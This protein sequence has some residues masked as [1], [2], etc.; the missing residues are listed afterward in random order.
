M[1]DSTDQYWSPSISSI[2]D[3]KGKKKSSAASKPSTDLVVPPVYWPYKYALEPV[4]EM[5]DDK[6][7]KMKEQ[8]RSLKHLSQ[9]YTSVQG[10]D[11]NIISLSSSNN[12]INFIVLDSSQSSSPR[13]LSVSM[14]TLEFAEIALNVILN[15]S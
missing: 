9:H 12:L 4:S 13:I 10:V 14:V 7:K 3:H 5:E 15:K 11:I 1:A 2:I 6:K 8:S